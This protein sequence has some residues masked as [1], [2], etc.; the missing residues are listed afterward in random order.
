LL[1]FLDNRLSNVNENGDPRISVYGI[2]GKEMYII[3]KPAEMT[4]HHVRSFDKNLYFQMWSG[5]V[6]IGFDPS[7]LAQGIKETLQGISF[8]IK[9]TTNTKLRRGVAYGA[10]KYGGVWKAA[11]IT[12]NRENKND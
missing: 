6:Q 8:N 4:R 5:Y 12:K 3:E 7:K 11:R 9:N 1:T 2:N 10:V